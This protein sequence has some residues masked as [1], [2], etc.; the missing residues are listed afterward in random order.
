MQG[1]REQQI[2]GVLMMQ[3]CCLCWNKLIVG[4]S[5]KKKGKKKAKKPPR[6]NSTQI[7]NIAV[8]VK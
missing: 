7:Q 8:F 2:F 1:S 5:K 6:N 4:Y 3:D